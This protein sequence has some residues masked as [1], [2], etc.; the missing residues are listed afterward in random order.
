MCVWS[1][2]IPRVSERLGQDSGLL[3][4]RML[5]LFPQ[6]TSLKVSLVN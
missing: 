5:T 2:G 1:G 6:V 3:A 4:G